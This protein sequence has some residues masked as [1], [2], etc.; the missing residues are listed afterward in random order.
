MAAAG[1]VCC[2]AAG[3]RSLRLVD[4]VVPALALRGETTTLRCAF[5]LESD[6]LYSVTWYKDHE[7]FFRFVPRARPPQTLHGLEGLVVDVS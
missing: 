2:P 7:E 1:H 3:S 5:D 6:R 4:V